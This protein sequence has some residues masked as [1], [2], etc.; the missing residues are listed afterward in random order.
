AAP[1]A[2]PLAAGGPPR[3]LLRLPEDRRG[4]LIRMAVRD[5]YVDVVTDR[6]QASVLMRFRDA[7]AEVD[8]VDGLQVHRSH[9]VA[10]AGVEG[11]QK[12]GDRVHVLTRDGERVPVSR[13]YRAD[14]V[15]RGLL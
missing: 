1:A 15:A 9:W 11:A 8:G 12:S 13:A 2:A 6:G 5:H 14:L 4:T 3:L 7:L 10:L